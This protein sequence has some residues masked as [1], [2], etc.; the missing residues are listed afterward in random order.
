MLC[1]CGFYEREGDCKLKH[2]FETDWRKKNST[3]YGTK[4]KNK[5]RLKDDFSFAQDTR[6]I[7][8]EFSLGLLFGC[9]NHKELKYLG[10][11]PI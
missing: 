9:Y 7:N 11:I 4:E 2:S 6:K 1:E 3:L 8:W 5:I 10:R